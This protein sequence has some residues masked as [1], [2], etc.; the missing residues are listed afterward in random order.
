MMP[1]P[2]DLPG[3]LARSTA[4][5]AALTTAAAAHAGGFGTRTMYVDAAAPTGSDGSSW[6]RA[7]RDL[8]DAIAQADATASQFAHFEIR[9]AQGVYTPDRGTGDRGASFVV[10]SAISLI[11]GFGGLRS[12]NPDERLSQFVTVLSG[13]L[14][15]NDGP[16]FA[17]R[18]DNA[19]HVVTRLGGDAS[20]VT[21]SSTSGTA[22]DGLTIRGGNADGAGDRSIGGGVFAVL[23]GST[24]SLAGCTIEDNRAIA[25]GGAFVVVGADNSITFSNGQILDNAG[26]GAAVSAA[27][28]RAYFL[29]SAV[30]RN[31]SDG[32]VAEFVSA[33]RT[34][35]SDNVGVGA[36]CR[37]LGVFDGCI[38]AG[39]R[40]GIHAQG[41]ALSLRSCLV[42]HNVR[43]S[44]GGG[45]Y[46]VASSNQI[47][48]CTIVGNSSAFAGGG[49][50]IEATGQPVLVEGSIFA[51][52]AALVA[53]TLSAD[54]IILDDVLTSQPGGIVSLVPPTQITPL[55][56]ADP[57]FIN[58]TGSDS[59]PLAWRDKNYRLRPD[60]PVIDAASLRRGSVA[61]DSPISYDADG[62]ARP[63]NVRCAAYARNDLGAFESQQII[64]PLPVPRVYVRADAA[65]GGDGRSWAGAYATI[66]QALAT[67]GV[68]N[69]WIAKGTY[70][71]DPVRHD[72]TVAF[73]I[74][75]PFVSVYGGFAGTETLLSQAAPGANPTVLSA[76]LL[77]NDSTDPNSRSDN[78]QMILAV[79]LPST[80]WPSTRT[81]R[82]IISGVRIT[83]A[84][85]PRSME[86]KAALSVANASVDVMD[87][88]FTN[89][90]SRDWPTSFSSFAG[91][92]ALRFYFSDA[93]VS[94]SRF[95][96]N[97]A[98][99]APGGAIYAA[100]SNVRTV[101]DCE[102]IGNSARDAGG[103]ISLGGSTYI[104]RSTF[105]GNRVTGRGG[106]VSVDSGSFENCRFVD[107]QAIGSL[108]A[109]GAVNAESAS[110]RNCVF[111]SN[112]SFSSSLGGGAI[113]SGSVRLDS[114]TLLD[115]TSRHGGQ[116]PSGPAV[117]ISAASVGQSRV[118]NTILYNND[119]QSAT[120]Y[121]IRTFEPGTTIF[122]EIMSCIVS[123]PVPPSA[124]ST[125]SDFPRFVNQ[126]G[127]DG[128]SGTLDDDLS[129]RP[130]SPAVDAGNSS[131]SVVGPTDILGNPRNV[132]IPSVTNAPGTID[133]G[134]YELQLASACRV[135]FNGSGGADLDDIFIY[136][137]AWFRQ[138]SVANFDAF[139]AI[140]LDD[141]FI[142]LNQWFAG[143]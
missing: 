15:A 98:I 105:V 117:V 118:Y 1:L 58:P 10:G 39:N 40:G 28:S 74:E 132:D 123:F 83:G 115:N 143:C 31:A 109:G 33:W 43:Q 122:P 142:F 3:T 41:A 79:D 91:G 24:L 45:V 102:F 12:P 92:G 59:S 86:H 138:E 23:S 36:W 16:Q 42:A 38:I 76:D 54:A 84:E 51:N 99:V 13:D 50:L 93:T 137:G 9:I 80:G 72:P 88:E 134:A 96:N 127:V 73:R 133:I 94:R 48:F 29:T 34:E 120:D 2:H 124:V 113:A 77:G 64:C 81:D 95:V 19:Y 67:P 135:D 5:L 27:G 112:R 141:L 110:F 111:R 32:V 125:K 107:N 17:N 53:P 47:S 82:N 139:P 46:S 30:R 106:A 130:D 140:T 8:Q 126:L 68:T 87:C 61:I 25:G 57:R 35:F 20:F 60:S 21:T 49:V 90:V 97:A 129:L 14:A 85:S 121:A 71:T 26:G 89:N 136:L 37:D 18:S 44:P 78:A 128:I 6:T 22:F 119:P 75:S 62:V 66:D 104:L 11:G 100:L 65:P 63:F 108:A 69:I 116:P 103:A 4:L 131:I 7:F 55:R 70:L 52:N 114:C 101:S 56:I